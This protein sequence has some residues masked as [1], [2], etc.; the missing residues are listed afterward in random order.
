MEQHSENIMSYVDIPEKKITC[1]LCFIEID[2]EIIN[3]HI[4]ECLAL[5][6]IHIEH[7]KIYKKHK[8]SE[9]CKKAYKY[10]TKKSKILSKYIYP[11]LLMKFIELDYTEDDL[12]TVIKYI[13]NEAPITINV[14]N[15]TII[16]YLVNDDHYKN[17]FEIG[18][19]HKAVSTDVRFCAES[20]MFN[21]LYDKCDAIDR[22][23]Y[24]SINLFDSEN[25]NP[26][27]L[28]YGD[29]VLVLK[30]EIKKRTSFTIGDSF[31]MQFHIGTFQYS[32]IFLINIKDPLIHA[33]ISFVK[34]RKKL[35]SYEILYLYKKGLYKKGECAYIEIQIHG[36]IRL[37]ED[38]EKIIINKKNMSQKINEFCDKNDIELVVLDA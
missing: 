20:N 14:R 3:Y 18:D 1:P 32:S 21:K 33:L 36:L 10:C 7:K 4:D 27:C 22:V 25:G 16:N 29:V 23:K 28:A 37:N 12:T 34:T 11:N 24:G 31:E 17:C 8:L 6:D 19:T 38:I 26:T 13:Q 9:V 15:E 5:N 2:T 35:A 30:N